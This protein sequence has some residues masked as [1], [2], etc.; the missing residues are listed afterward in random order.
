VIKTS[1]FGT[2]GIR[3]D[4]EKLFTNQFCF[5]IARAFVIFLRKNNQD[6]AIAIGMDPRGSSPRIKDAVVSGIT[7]EGREVKDEGTASVPSIN[8]ILEVSEY[9][10]ASL[11]VSGS[12]IKSYLNGIKFFAFDKEILKTHEKEISDIYANIKDSVKYQKIKDSGLVENETIANETYQDYLVGHA[13]KS[14]PGWKVVVD[15]GDGAQSDTMPQ[16]LK[17]L[18]LN[19][20][21]INCT[22]QGRFYS[23]DTEVE[24]DFEGLKNEVPKN[25]ANFGIGYDSDGDRCVFVDERGNFIP[26]DYTGALLAT[27]F[28]KDKVVTPINSSQVID[29]LGLE[30]IRTK[31][32][33]P[34]VVDA[35]IKN[36][37]SFGYEAN[38]GCIFEDMYSRDGGRTT[39]EILNIIAKEGKNLSQIIASLPKFYLSRDKVEYKWELKDKIISEAKNQFKGEKIEEIDGLKIWIDKTT[40]ILFRSS[41]NAPEFRVF[42]E[43]D[44]QKKSE[45]LL[46]EGLAL[47]KKII[48][49]D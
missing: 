6:G 29:K 30:V 43:S 28:S 15:P 4:A 26:G 20:V 48:K 44:N 21:E 31:V 17:R 13:L 24:R 16:V 36:K 45:E 37:C 23:R 49:D 46:E 19:V 7:Y 38:G 35:M 42:A 18:G 33:S 2:S 32:G 11:M 9:I 1:L 40:W 10:C 25:N 41:S 8:Y 34:F 5:D 22:I 27:H 14:Y 3:G 12:H 47:V 39:V